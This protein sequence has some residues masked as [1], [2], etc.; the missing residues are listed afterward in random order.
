MTLGSYILQKCLL[1]AHAKTSLGGGL[2]R[3]ASIL[4][5]DYRP[6]SLDRSLSE[7]PYKSRANLEN[8]NQLTEDEELQRR[9]SLLLAANLNEV[10]VKQALQVHLEEVNEDMMY[11]G[12]E[13]VRSWSEE[14]CSR[15]SEGR[16]SWL[17]DAK[18]QNLC[19]RLSQMYRFATGTDKSG[20][21]YDMDLE[22]TQAK[23][24]PPCKSYN[25]GS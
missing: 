3:P 10:S 19:L 22:V 23:P 16:L 21:S 18:I 9:V 5:T 2:S 12:W 13:D 7:G 25:F 6:G 8:A 20:D 24:G 15:V 14:V 11:Y 4:P 17:D 1:G